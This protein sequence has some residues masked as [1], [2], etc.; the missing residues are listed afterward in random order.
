M[1]RAISWKKVDVVRPQP[2]HALTWGR[3]DRK[4]SDWR[5]CWATWTSSVRSPPGAGVSDTRI[6]S[7]M[8]SLSRID[9][10]AVE[11]MIPLV[12]SPASVRPRWSG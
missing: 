2:G 4:P 5:T 9:R 11:A 8:P 1:S 6:V 3:K 7:P 10:P 12:P